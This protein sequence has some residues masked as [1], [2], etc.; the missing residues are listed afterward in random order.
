MGG[1][2]EMN[3]M[4]KPWQRRGIVLT[5]IILCLLASTAFG[6]NNY[7]PSGSS[8]SVIA[9]NYQIEIIPPTASNYIDIPSRAKQS[10]TNGEINRSFEKLLLAELPEGLQQCLYSTSSVA[11]FSDSIHRNRLQRLYQLTDIPPPVDLTM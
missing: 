2:S 3:D 6:F 1:F 4:R 9:L 5:F 8:Q 7:I 10:K 11:G